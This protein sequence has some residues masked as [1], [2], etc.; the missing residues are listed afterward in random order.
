MIGV[1]AAPHGVRGTLRV[2][3]VGN[4][5]HLREG[6]APVLNG[7]RHRI[8]TSRPTPK[9]FLIDFD[10]FTD[11]S[12]VEA[13]RGVEL[14]LDRSELDEADEGEVYVSDLVGLEVFGGSGEKLG[15]VAETFPTA[16]HE[17]LI[18]RDADAPELYLPFTLEHVPDVDL[19]AGRI[20]A[21]PPEPDEG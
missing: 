2:K 7:S 14:T 15:T 9:G 11:R 18:I 21:Q 20:T 13:L 12:E 6:V 5:R 4:G 1:I 10:E 3:P 17:I 8:I 19:V 16:A